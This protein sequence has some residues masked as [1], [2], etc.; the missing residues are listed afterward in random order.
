MAVIIIST[1]TKYYSVKVLF[2]CKSPTEIYTFNDIRI[3]MFLNVF[4]ERRTVLN[5]A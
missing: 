4:M 5:K 2:F 1:H 3:E